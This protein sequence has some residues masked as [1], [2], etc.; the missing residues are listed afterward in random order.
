MLNSMFEGKCGAW[1][2]SNKLLQ[3]VCKKGIVILCNFNKLPLQRKKRIGWRYMLAQL[4]LKFASLCLTY[5]HRTSY[6]WRKQM[7]SLM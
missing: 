4:N 3:P 1:F 5:V 7:D 2:Y 6:C